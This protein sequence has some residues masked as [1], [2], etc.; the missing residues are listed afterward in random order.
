MA[1]E[2]FDLTPLVQPL[3]EVGG[4]IVAG[5][6]TAVAGKAVA[7]LNKRFD[8]DFSTAQT[9]EVQ[10]VVASTASVLEQH[11]EK[12]VLAHSELKTSNPLV[13]SAASEALT[14]GS[15]LVSHLNVETVAAAAI[16]RVE[17]WIGLG[18]TQAPGTNTAA[19]SIT[20]VTMP[21]EAATAVADAVKGVA[22]AEASKVASTVVTDALAGAS[23][24]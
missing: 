24:K 7:Y 3:V 11:V 21:A 6:L 5:V 14:L 4:L 2:A 9:A 20:H 13:Q 10:S 23:T 8:L 17:Q 18:I 12:G 1:S 16:K 22:A 15:T 19:P